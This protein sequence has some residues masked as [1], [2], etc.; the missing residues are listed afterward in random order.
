[1]TVFRLGADWQAFPVE[2]VDEVL[3][4]ATPHP[5]PDAGPEL[6]G[7]LPWRG[8]LIPVVDL[9]LRLG[10][11]E[12]VTAGFEVIVLRRA[13]RKVGVAV[14]GVAGV[15][16]FPVGA[17]EVVRMGDEVVTLLDPAE[18]FPFDQTEEQVNESLESE[19]TVQIV[20]FRVGGQDFGLDVF[21]VHEILRHQPVTP[22]P[23]APGFV[24]GVIDVRGTLVPVIDVRR[25]FEAPEAKVDAETRIVVV[26]FDG[27]RLGLM[28]DAVS[29]V[30]RLPDSQ[31]SD[32][33]SYVRGI[34]A[35][36]IKGIV[37]GRG[38]LI[39]V[40]ELD[41]VLSS[42]ERIALQEADLT[43]P[44]PTEQPGPPKSKSKAKSK[45]K[46]KTKP[47]SSSKPRSKP[48]SRSGSKKSSRP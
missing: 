48:K 45:A 23:K 34:A 7:V 25:R 29:E 16:S 35:E 27:E 2:S 33:P 32:P 43:P 31:L 14:D 20:T 6:L 46:P 9:A 4:G 17:G 12:P 1:M 22:V 11:G 41:R 30:L 47:K 38:Q 28:V 39:I 13:G 18:I 8:A 24:E 10:G 42:Q 36:F 21:S 37:R 5:V 15:R 3:A 26:P 19:Q 44:E 40:L